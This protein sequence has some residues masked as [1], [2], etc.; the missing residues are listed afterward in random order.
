MTYEN[1]SHTNTINFQVQRIQCFQKKIWVNFEFR[2]TKETTKDSTNFLKITAG[3]NS[4]I[5]FFGKQV[6]YNAF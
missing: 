1:L 3:N 2:S 6:P 4:A 5:T